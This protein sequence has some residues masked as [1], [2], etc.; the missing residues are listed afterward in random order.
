MIGSQIGI[1]KICIPLKKEDLKESTISLYLPKIMETFDANASKAR[2][3]F[4]YFKNSHKINTKK[5]PFDD[6]SEI[7]NKVAVGHLNAMVNFKKG[8]AYGNPIEYA[9]SKELN[10]DDIRYLDRYH[11]DCNK[12]SLDSQVAEWVYS[13]GNCYYFI[14][15]K[16]MSEVLDIKTESPYNIYCKKPIEAAKI[17]SSYNGNRELFDILV[18]SIE[19]EVEGEETEIKIIVSVYT[20]NFYYEFYK[21]ES[22]DDFIIDKKK[23]VVRAIYKNLPLTEKYANENRLGMVEIARTMNDAIDR[24]YSNSLDNIEETVNTMLVFL[25][26]T[27][28]KD[29]DEEAATLKSARKNGAIVITSPNKDIQADIKPIEVKLNYSDII[30]LVEQITTT[31]YDICGVPLSS[32]DTSGGGNK[33]GALRLGNGWENAYNRLLDEINSFISADYDVLKKQLFICKRVVNSKINELN[34]SEIDIKYSPNMTD[35]MLSKSQS[36]KYFIE[37]G[38]P[39]EIAIAW[40]RLS[41]DPITQGKMIQAYMD[42]KKDIDSG[43]AVDINNSEVVKTQK[44]ISE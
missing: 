15:P 5:R 11:K 1:K 42:S 4:E 8:Y 27:L 22:D 25:N 10:T 35:N 33:Q 40:C 43:N 19:E 44:N 32:S 2:E 13:V 17:Y 3:L 12:R 26:C 37:C 38:V 20:P 18:T 28:G 7:N 21:K 14:E 16:P 34:A 41:N 29:S 36:Y 30:A 6:V 23:T 9:Q 24:I 31:M 39:P